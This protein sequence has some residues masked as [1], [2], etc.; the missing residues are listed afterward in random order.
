M[1][2]LRSIGEG[3]EQNIVRIL[4]CIVGSKTL[5]ETVTYCSNLVRFSHLFLACHV[6]YN[7]V[8]MCIACLVHS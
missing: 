4:L 5:I 1:E 7:H 2:G 3:D 6:Q 8:Y